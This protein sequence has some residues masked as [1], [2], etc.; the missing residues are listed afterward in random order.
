MQSEYK[1]NHS[2]ITFVT[3]A[4]STRGINDGKAAQK[5]ERSGRWDDSLVCQTVARIPTFATPQIYQFPLW[6]A[7]NI[8]CAN[9]LCLF[10]S[11]TICPTA[12]F[13]CIE[14][15]GVNQGWCGGVC[16]DKIDESTLRETLPLISWVTQQP[17]EILSH[18]VIQDWITE[19]NNPLGV[20][21]DL[22]FS[23]HKYLL[24]VS[25][26]EAILHLLSQSDHKNNDLPIA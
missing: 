25:G 19:E 16:R 22:N 9:S 4:N 10:V 26:K 2:A 5:K 12:D 13:G 15:Q 17:R 23:H 14:N 7:S 21:Q 8:Y 18:F 20:I 1:R 6:I 24:P 11:L 3:M